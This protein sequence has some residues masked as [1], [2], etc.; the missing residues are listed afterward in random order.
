MPFEEVE[1]IYPPSEYSLFIA[2]GYSKINALRKEKFLAAKSLG[3]QLPSYISPKAFCIK[4][5]RD[6]GKLFYFGR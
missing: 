3:Y 5:R 6:W 2:L 1:Q 4:R